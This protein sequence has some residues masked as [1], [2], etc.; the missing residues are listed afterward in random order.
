M[1]SASIPRPVR[2]F[3]KQLRNVLVFA[4]ATAAV[5]FLPPPGIA[6]VD[7]RSDT[8]RASIRQFPKPIQIEVEMV[9][10]NVTV[11]D[12]DDRPMM[13]LQKD[14]FRLFE[15]NVEQEILDFSH[16]DAPVSI[17]ILIDMSGSMADKIDK[18]RPAVLQI[19][20][21]ANP[22]DEFLLVSFADH[23]KLT[24]GFTSNIAEL[25]NSM[26]SN[27]P[28]GS[29]ALLDA[30]HLGMKQMR[31]AKYRRR[32][33]VVI[34]DGGD[35]HSWHSESRI[36][37]ELKEADCQLYAIGIYDEHD[38]KLTVEEHNGPQLLFEMAK[39]T[40]GRAF[41]VSSLDELPSIAAKISMELR[42]QYVLGYKPGGGRHDGTWRSI[43]V[44]VLPPTSLRQCRAQTKPHAR[45]SW[46]SNRT[47]WP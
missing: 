19:L 28:K 13:D 24:S 2:D 3:Q 8:S 4:L 44:K 31:N 14:D 22:Q 12:P 26:M 39:I 15:N 40:G 6:Q 25:Q 34:S 1:I 42:D 37:K 27:K 20:K 23:A 7:G 46:K 11:T 18:A 30:I 21:T 32:A 5:A 47:P 43:K 29:T 36:R 10:V 33:L 9:L 35:N 41:P 17:G 45:A 38:M 16:Q